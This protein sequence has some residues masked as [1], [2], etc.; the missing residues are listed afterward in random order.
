[1]TV[2][3]MHYDFKVQLNEVDTN[4]ARSLLVQEIDWKLNQ[5]QDILLNQIANPNSGQSGVEF[6]QRSRS[7]IGPVLVD[8]KPIN[9]QP[10]STTQFQAAYPTDYLYF[11]SAYADADKGLCSRRIRVF[12]VQHDDIHEEYAFST[13]SFEW[14][15]IN[16][17][18][19]EDGFK[20]FSDGTFQITKF[21]LDYIRK[22]L[23]I[24]NAKQVGAAGYRLP[25][26]GTLTGKQDCELGESLHRSI[27]SLAV[28][29][30]TGDLRLPDYQ[31]KLSNF[32][33]ANQ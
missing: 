26:G 29:L 4:R 22:P 7:D 1:M 16:A 25:D 31:I 27:V 33:I 6:S 5:A 20:L 28:L 30:T 10:L 11:A 2:E 32:Q 19:Y 15:E 21:Y 17:R 18:E 23:Y 3:N 12:Q 13:S 14:E 24:H 9:I 8:A